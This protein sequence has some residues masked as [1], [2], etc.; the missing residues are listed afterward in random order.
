M[1][2]RHGLHTSQGSR[3]VGFGVD[4]SSVGSGFGVSVGTDVSVADDRK[5]K[6]VPAEVAILL[7]PR[8][9]AVI[10][11]AESTRIVRVAEMR[12]LRLFIAISLSIKLLGAP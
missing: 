11:R 4:K 2:L 6:S 8:T 10:A 5:P 7:R 1:V 12:V 9:P 3:G